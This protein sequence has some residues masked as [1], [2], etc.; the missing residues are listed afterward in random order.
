M[1]GIF[2]APRWN[3]R[4]RR[5]DARQ[6]WRHPS[7]PIK[8]FF[9]RKNDQRFLDVLARATSDAMLPPCPELRADVI[10]NRNAALMQSVERHAN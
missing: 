9:E 4:G 5:A 1:G 3:G 6:T 10:D 8:L 7:I 2:G